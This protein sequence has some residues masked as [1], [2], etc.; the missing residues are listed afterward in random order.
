MWRPWPVSYTHL[1]VYK[2]Q[3]R[4]QQDCR[5]RGPLQHP[6]PG[7]PG[8]GAGLGRGGVARHAY[9]CLLY[10]SAVEENL[11]AAAEAARQIRLRNLSGILLIDLID[12]QSDAD[13]GQ[14]CIRDRF[15]NSP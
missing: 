1:D 7:L 9:H 6:Y 8:R 2:R 14:M 15:D 11:R 12:M 13:R 10:T 4:Y 3:P 5:R